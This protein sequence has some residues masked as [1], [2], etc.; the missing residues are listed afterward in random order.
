MFRITFKLPTKCF[1]CSNPARI[2]LELS[3]NLE[4]GV[5]VDV[6]VFYGRILTSG[7]TLDVFICG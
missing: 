4:K 3:E 6:L 5:Q 2:V 7:M 1:Q